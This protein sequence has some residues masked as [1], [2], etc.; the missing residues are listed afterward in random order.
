MPGK[1]IKI[2]MNLF[3]EQIKETETARVGLEGERLK[4]KRERHGREYEESSVER[5]ERKEER[6]QE[7]HENREYHTEDRE[8][9]R[10]ER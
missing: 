7:R 10:E 2:E 4:F 5:K 8:E 3:G 1:F 9:R 6:E